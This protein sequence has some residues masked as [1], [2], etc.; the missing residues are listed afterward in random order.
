MLTLFTSLPTIIMMAANWESQIGFL[1]GDPTGMPEYVKWLSVVAFLLA[2]FLQAYV[3]LTAICP[4]YLAR[5]SII[6]QEKE[7]QEEA[8]K[9]IGTHGF[10]DHGT[11]HEESP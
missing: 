4:L 11:E 3:W 2:G 6:L 10:L 7:R 1:N 8:R 5:T 9:R